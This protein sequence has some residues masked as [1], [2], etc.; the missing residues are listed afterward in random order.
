M[1]AVM[2][3]IARAIGHR[4]G[5]MTGVAVACSGS[6]STGRASKATSM[7]FSCAR[8]RVGSGDVGSGLS[9][10]HKK[11]RG[12]RRGYDGHGLA[13]GGGCPLVKRRGWGGR[14]EGCT[15]SWKEASRTLSVR[16]ESPPREDGGDP[17]LASKPERDAG[18]LAVT[19]A[20][21]QQVGP[22]SLCPC[23]TLHLLS[24]CRARVCVSVPAE[25][26]PTAAAGA[27][28]LTLSR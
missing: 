28:A 4:A 5:G 1:L 13:R 19:Q 15:G 24:P 3:L 8:G 23:C 10:S 20:Q 14:G 26:R 2:S 21:I 7:A 27:A 17:G 22:H 25:E 12:G 9:R 11:G 16:A 18:L 6:P